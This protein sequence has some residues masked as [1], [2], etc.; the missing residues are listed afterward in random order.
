MHALAIQETQAVIS[1]DLIDKAQ[2]Y[3]A[4]STADAT[5]RAYAFDLQAW[6]AWCKGQGTNPAAI[7]PVTVALYVTDH[8]GK[9]SI[10]T[11]E[12]RIAGIN[13]YQRAN[14]LE[15]V[16][17]RAEPLKSVWAG[18]RR[19]HGT[20]QTRKTPIETDLL[21]SV[22][23]GLGDSA[24]DIRDKALLVIGFAGGLR[25]ADL[26]GMDSAAGYGG[27]SFATVTDAGLVVSF[28]RSKTDQTGQGDLIGLAYGGDPR[29]C[30]VRAYTALVDVVGQGPLF[31]SINRHGHISAE[32]LTPDS[33]A[34]IIKRRLVAFKTEQG[35]D[36]ATAKAWA[37]DY[38]G[39]SLRAGFVT[40]ALGR[41]IAESAIM[42]HTRHK[43]TETLAKYR[44][45]ATLFTDNPSAKVG[46]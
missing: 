34:R 45:P 11:L 40:A 6:A 31:R 21:R 1:A 27:N 28:I 3:A 41:G 24:A 44:R 29:T 42:P 18:V 20:P 30:P 7:N 2:D 37:A 14:G 39:H 26:A 4:Q 8:A 12:R 25:R 23:S 22:V 16:S 9:L 35:V 17:T 43:K 10:A 5:R 38:S 36:L 19:V 13:A 33:V 46:L 32:R 15:Q